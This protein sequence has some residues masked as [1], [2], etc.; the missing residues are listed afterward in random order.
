MINYVYDV[1]LSPNIIARSVMNNYVYDVMLCISM[2]SLI[3]TNPLCGLTIDFRMGKKRKF[4]MDATK[5]RKCC[6]KC[7]EVGVNEVPLSLLCGVAIM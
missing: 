7:H 1:M 6:C 4:N 3:C 5:S 2:S